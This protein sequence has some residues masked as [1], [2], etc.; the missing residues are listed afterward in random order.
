[1]PANREEWLII[2]SGCAGGIS[3]E[4]QKELDSIQLCNIDPTPNT[5][6]TPLKRMMAILPSLSTQEKEALLDQFMQ[7]EV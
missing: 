4:E 7:Q 5:R 3:P 2:K 6:T 1:M